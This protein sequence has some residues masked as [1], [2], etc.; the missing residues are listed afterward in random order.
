[1]HPVEGAERRA[2]EA[3]EITGR[4]AAKYSINGGIIPGTSTRKLAHGRAQ[5]EEV[6]REKSRTRRANRF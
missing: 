1:M 3:E 4:A 6:T 5:S 2:P